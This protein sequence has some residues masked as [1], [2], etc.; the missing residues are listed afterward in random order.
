VEKYFLKLDN[1]SGVSKAPRHLGE[2]EIKNFQFN[3]QSPA[4]G[5]VL[6]GKAQTNGLVIGK[7]SDTASHVLAAAYNSGRVFAEGLLTVET[8]SPK[9]GLLRTTTIRMTSLYIANFSVNGNGETIGF[10]FQGLEIV[11]PGKNKEKDNGWEKQ[12]ERLKRL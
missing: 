8:L 4:A 10:D 6:W 7:N 11:Q 5:N 1:M 9:G 3:Q 12:G 2:I